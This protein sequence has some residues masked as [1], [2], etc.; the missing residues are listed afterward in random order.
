[1]SHKNI[2]AKLMKDILDA[3]L[4]DQPQYVIQALQQ[5]LDLQLRK[6]AIGDEPFPDGEQ[7]I[8]NLL[9]EFGI[10]KAK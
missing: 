3:K 7:Q 2:I 1:M 5:Q 8:N 9:N 10:E 4:T 6:N